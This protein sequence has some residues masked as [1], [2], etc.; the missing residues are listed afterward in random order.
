MRRLLCALLLAAGAPLGLAAP[1]AALSYGGWSAR[2]GLDSWHDDNLARGSA[3]SAAALPRGNQDLGARL[4]LSVGNV[5]VWAPEVETWLLANASG[6]VGLFYPE[7]GAFWGSLYGQTVWRLAP[8]RELFW[9]AGGTLYGAAGTYLATELGLVQ[10]LWPG[11]SARLEAGGALFAAEDPETGFALPSAGVGID[12]LLPT[13]TQL[14]ARYALQRQAFAAY[15][16]PRHQASLL[17]SQRLAPSWELHA[18]Y[19]ATIV[20]DAAA[21]YVEGYAN[22]G[23]SFEL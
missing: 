14:G 17:L 11:A 13:G 6:S 15:A 18:Q 2:A 7:L 10:A 8:G 5:F 12:Q 4:S 3:I 23:V 20:P 22:L 21:G 16:L 19:L 1:A 9:L